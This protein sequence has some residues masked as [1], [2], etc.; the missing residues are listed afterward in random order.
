MKSSQI[1]ISYGKVSNN[2]VGFKKICPMELFFIWPK[3]L[4]FISSSFILLCQRLY[5]LSIP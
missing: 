4:I 5:P 2:D 1:W 3:E